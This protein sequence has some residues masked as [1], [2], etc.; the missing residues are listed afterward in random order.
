MLKSKA[1]EHKRR[2]AKAH[3]LHIVTDGL[4]GH[5]QSAQIDDCRMRILAHLGTPSIL[6]TWSTSNWCVI[7]FCCTIAANSMQRHA[8]LMLSSG[9]QF[10][11]QND[12]CHVKRSMN[13]MNQIIFLFQLQNT[14][15]PKEI[16]TIKE[17][18]T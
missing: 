8:G 18:P 9:Q 5:V 14:F 12:L 1:A 15:N 16:A 11:L 4:H 6:P 3:K 13:N 10:L 17:M 7:M 2:H